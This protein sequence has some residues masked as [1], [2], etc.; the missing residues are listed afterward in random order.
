MFDRQLD[1]LLAGLVGN[2]LTRLDLVQQRVYPG[3]RPGPADGGLVFNRGRDRQWNADVGLTRVLPERTT[4]AAPEV[5]RLSRATNSS[6]SPAYRS[7][8]SSG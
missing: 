3:T 6:V 2:I 8:S 4:M 1:D 7:E 5:F